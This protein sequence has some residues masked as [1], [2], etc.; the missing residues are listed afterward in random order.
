MVAICLIVG[1]GRPPDPGAPQRPCRRSIY[2]RVQKNRSPSC[3][4]GA[5]Y[6]LQ[7][8]ETAVPYIVRVAEMFHY[9][10]P[11]EAYDLEPCATLEEA[12]EAA[13][14]LVE[15]DLR[16]LV[17]N[18]MS[19]EDLVKTW[20]GF[21]LDPFILCPPGVERATFRAAGYVTERAPA[22]VGT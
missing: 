2:R 17:R 19:A 5:T 21:G 3:R 9:M 18:G 12:E 1:A 4:R 7:P 15:R 16:H 20:Y 6:V 14:Q 10:D 8:S 11:D 22:I 13:R